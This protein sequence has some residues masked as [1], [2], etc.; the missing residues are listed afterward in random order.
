MGE[1]GGVHR[2]PIAAEMI[3]LTTVKRCGDKG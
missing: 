2:E 3:I 1:S